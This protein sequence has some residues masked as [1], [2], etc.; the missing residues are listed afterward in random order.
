[1][2]L[3]LQYAKSASMSIMQEIRRILIGAIMATD[4]T[5]HFALTSSF[6]QHGTVWSLGSSDD[7]LLLCKAILHAAD[8]SNPARP[9]PI[10]AAMSIRLHEE[11]KYASCVAVT[12]LLK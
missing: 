7:S 2:M 8:L 10:N 5:K 3:S 11:F 9:F 6:C 1:M 12:Y 4:I